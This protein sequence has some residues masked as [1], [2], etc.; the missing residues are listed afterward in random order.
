MEQQ[1]LCLALLHFGGIH[2]WLIIF[3]F[4]ILFLEF[5]IALSQA[6]IN[7]LLLWNDDL[8]LNFCISNFYTLFLSTTAT[9]IFIFNLSEVH[10]FN[11]DMGQFYGI[12]IFFL[13]SWLGLFRDIQLFKLLWDLTVTYFPNLHRPVNVIKSNWKTQKFPL[14]QS[15]HFVCWSEWHQFKCPISS[16]RYLG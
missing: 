11:Y 16:F 12:K 15:P 5:G 2:L 9:G 6:N 7:K 10:A 14:F 13:N 8:S 1:T 3:D 4:L